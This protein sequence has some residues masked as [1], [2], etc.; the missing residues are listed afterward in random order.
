[1]QPWAFLC[2]HEN[3]AEAATVEV[4]FANN[5]ELGEQFRRAVA[6]NAKLVPLGAERLLGTNRLLL[7]PD[8]AWPEQPAGQFMFWVARKELPDYRAPN[9]PLSEEQARLLAIAALILLDA[10]RAKGLELSFSSEVAQAGGPDTIHVRRVGL[11]T[12]EGGELISWL[13]SLDLGPDARAIVDDLRDEAS[14]RAFAA[15]KGPEADGVAQIRPDGTSLS[16]ESLLASSFWEAP[17]E[18]VG[19]TSTQRPPQLAQPV[20]RPA[21]PVEPATAIPTSSPDSTTVPV[22]SLWARARLGKVL[23][24]VGAVPVLFLGVVGAV[25]VVGAALI[26]TGHPS[27]CVKRTPTVDPAAAAQLS[28]DW[29]EF[30]ARANGGPTSI[31]LTESEVTSRSVEYLREKNAPVSNLRIYFCPDG[32]AEAA[33]SI[34]LL[35]R[36]IQV[37]ASGTLDLTG[38]QPE[39]KNN[40]VR[41][42]NLPGK[43]STW[44]VNLV[45][46]VGNLK[47][48]KL[49]KHLTA[50]TFA[51]GTTTISGGPTRSAAVEGSQMTKISAGGVHACDVNPDHTVS[52]WG[53]N[54]FGQATPPDGAFSAVSAGARHTCALKLDNTLVCWGANGSRQ[55]TPPAG[56]FLEVSAGNDFTCAVTMD[57]AMSCWGVSVRGAARPPSDLFISVSAGYYHVCAIKADG[58]VACWGDNTYHQA[59]PPADSFTSLSAGAFHTCGVT[60]AGTIACWGGNGEH[61]TNAPNGRFVSVG[62]GEAH[63]CGVRSDG[64]ITCW[65][66]DNSSES[67]APPGDFVSVS[68]G[69]GFTC[70]VQR[71][72]TVACWGDNRL[73]QAAPRGPTPAGVGATH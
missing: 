26:F 14:L 55:A 72:R 60:T 8:E 23:I 67:D 20:A 39:I 58:F 22:R 35:G 31:T 73:G 33:A 9:R 42:G 17:I 56:E 43:L 46:D 48:L 36:D 4:H 2:V 64:S 70:G 40:S 27:P 34:S 7:R 41:A 1:M 5:L 12:P 30:L 15:G 37:V 66:R 50:I 21:E 69:T 61:Q 24:V 62:A 63:T 45:L 11:L 3:S 57:G 59:T 54:T 38:S 44:A 29:L 71:D 16:D 25:T 53:G 13:R 68:A 51:D 32:H 18:S 65:G 49:D 47:T 6:A 10:A 19:S 28:G 52:C